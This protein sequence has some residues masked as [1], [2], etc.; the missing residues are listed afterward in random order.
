MARIWGV[1]N[2]FVYEVLHMNRLLFGAV[3]LALS[4]PALSC[5]DPTSNLR[6]GVAQVTAEPTSV[7]LTQGLTTQITVRVLDEQGNELA[8]P[9][10]FTNPNPA[11]VTVAEDP[12]FLVGTDTTAPDAPIPSKTRT[13]L[14]ITGV[15]VDT[16]HITVSS[17]GV[18]RNIAYRVLPGDPSG[19]FSSAVSFSTPTP[20]TNEVVTLSATGFKFLAHPAPTCACA[21]TVL[22]VSFA[23]GGDAIIVGVSADS[24]TVSFLPVP[25]SG[26]DIT[27]NGAALAFLPSVP[28]AVTVPA[29]SFTAPPA[30]VGTNDPATAPVIALPA[31]GQT[32]T[33]FDAGSFGAAVCGGNTG[34]PC[35]L[36]KFTVAAGTTL[37]ASLSWPNAA[38]MGLYIMDAAGSANIGQQCDAAGRG[39]GNQPEAC[40]LVLTPGTYL[41]GVINFGPAYAEADPN[42]PWFMITLTAP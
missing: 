20:A 30:F 23:G 6:G 8:D 36:Y 29:A 38:D 2:I 25:G 32:D 31:S 33:I 3:V 1:W 7:F 13:R 16:G 17:G 12:T 11:N 14:L 18:D 28:F 37:H 26:G 10:T 4:L 19:V 42:P 5:G 15:A 41:A 40:D 35:Q 9:V 22:R 34:F 24:S 27:V 39:A 21:D